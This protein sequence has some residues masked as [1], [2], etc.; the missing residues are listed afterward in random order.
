MLLEGT[1]H[2]EAYTSLGRGSGPR[3]V[4]NSSEI[5]G[6]GGFSDSRYSTDI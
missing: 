2:K 6:K 1:L 4:G 3:N 5:S